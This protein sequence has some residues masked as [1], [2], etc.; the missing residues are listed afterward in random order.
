MTSPRRKRVASP[1][2]P[3]GPLERALAAVVADARA[4]VRAGHAPDRRALEARVR[5]V[6]E[7]GRGAPGGAGP[8]DLAQAERAALEAIE[9]VAAVHRAYRRLAQPA[10]PPRSSA[11]ASRPSATPRRLGGL[12]PRATVTGTLDVRRSERD[13][14]PVL[15]WSRVPA[16]RT[17]EVRLAE[18]RDV[19]ADYALTETVVLPPET[20]SVEIPLGDRPLRVSVIGQ[21]RDG[22]PLR[23]ALVAGLT[24]ESWPGRWERR[25]TAS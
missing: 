3:A 7:R 25:A 13:G 17:W 2:A 18:K 15:E 14:R 20:T 19:R 6:V 23:R 4:Q 9:R 10:E 11:P 21:A 22:R 16:V 24:V 1:P 12:R 5:G 8:E